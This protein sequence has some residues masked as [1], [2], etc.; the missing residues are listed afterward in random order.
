VVG[1]VDGVADADLEP[2][3]GE[4]ANDPEFV[5]LVV[6]DP[7]SGLDAGSTVAAVGVGHAGA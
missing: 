7:L 5:A 1:P 2:L 6:V 4:P 3:L